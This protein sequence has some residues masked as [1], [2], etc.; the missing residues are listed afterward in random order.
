MVINKEVQE[1]AQ[2]TIYSYNDVL[3]L[4]DYYKDIEAVKAVLEILT[5]SAI[6]IYDY[7][8]LLIQLPSISR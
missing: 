6:S 2:S 1:L 5:A 4:Y 7:L 3:I 8:K